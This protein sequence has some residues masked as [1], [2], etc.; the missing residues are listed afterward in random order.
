V[1]DSWTSPA[2]LPV[3]QTHLVPP[4][5]MPPKIIGGS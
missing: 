5:S 3:A 1:T 4:A 2:P